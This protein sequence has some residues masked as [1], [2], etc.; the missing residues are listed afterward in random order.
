MYNKNGR[1]LAIFVY[2]EFLKFAVK[3]KMRKKEA[4]LQRV[5]KLKPFVWLSPS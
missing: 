3:M 5:R 2:L 1:F 4:F